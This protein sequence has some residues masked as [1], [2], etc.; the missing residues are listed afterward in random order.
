MSALDDLEQTSQKLDK[1]E[2][3]LKGYNPG[4]E[5]DENGRF[6]SMGGPGSAGGKR[7]PKGSGKSGGRGSEPKYNK[8][9]SSDKNTAAMHG[10]SY[11]SHGKVEPGTPAPTPRVKVNRV[12]PDYYSYGYSKGSPQ[13]RAEYRSISKLADRAVAEHN[14]ATADRARLEKIWQKTG[15]Q[16]GELNAARKREQTAKEHVQSTMEARNAHPEHSTFKSVG[17]TRVNTA[18]R[19]EKVIPFEVHYNPER[20]K[21]DRQRTAAQGLKPKKKELD[22]LQDLIEDTKVAIKKYQD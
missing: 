15:S 3:G 16:R 2:Q 22:E 8:D 14:A 6:A 4:Q 10:P 11:P 20:A 7:G 21:L 13:S 19:I 9:S 12:Q 1:I 17:N 5:R 18:R